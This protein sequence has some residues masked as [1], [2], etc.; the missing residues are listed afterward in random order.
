MCDEHERR[1]T[2]LHAKVG[3]QSSSFAQEITQAYSE[4]LL[5]SY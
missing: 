5:R 3:G 2:Q 4:R 1:L